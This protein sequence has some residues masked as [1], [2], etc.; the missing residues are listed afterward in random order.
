[1]NTIDLKTMVPAG[2]NPQD[3]YFYYNKRGEVDFI[4]FPSGPAGRAAFGG[5]Q[6]ELLSIGRLSPVPEAN[7]VPTRIEAPVWMLERG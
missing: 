7:R 2:T 1:M 4:K 5:A 6:D 3:I